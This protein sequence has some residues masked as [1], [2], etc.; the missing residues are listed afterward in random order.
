LIG[1]GSFGYV[2]KCKHVQTGQYYAIKYFKNKFATMKKA[3]D[4]REIQILQ[5]FNKIDKKGPGNHCPFVMKAERIE[6]E[7]RK[8]FIVFEQMDMSLT[9][10]IK[11]KVKSGQKLDEQNEIKILMKQIL[12]GMQYLNEECGI[13]HRD[14]K[15]D[16]IMVNVNPLIA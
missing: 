10:F 7:N 16:N 14:L 12:T 2:Y 3:F 13:L 8:L 9:Q 4:Q 5:R 1:G 6:Y 11:R 15:P